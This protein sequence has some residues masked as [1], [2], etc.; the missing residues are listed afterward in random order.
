[1]GVING[2]DS[3]LRPDEFDCGFPMTHVVEDR[4]VIDIP[5]AKVVYLFDHVLAVI[6]DMIGAQLYP[7]PLSRAVTKWR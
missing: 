7:M 2:D 3:A 4:D 6:H 5:E 1:M